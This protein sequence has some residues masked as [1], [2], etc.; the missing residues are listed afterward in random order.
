MTTSHYKKTKKQLEDKPGKLEKWKK[1][2]TPKDRSTGQAKFKCKRCGR[3]GAHIHKYDLHLC[4]QCFR[5]I[6]PDI[7][8][9]K[10]S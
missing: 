2:N 5:E 6:A 4:R 10:Y 8:F 3:H 7:G 1:H 9:K